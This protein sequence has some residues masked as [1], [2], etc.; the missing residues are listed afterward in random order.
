M[1]YATK[2][3]IKGQIVIPGPLRKKHH[4]EPGTTVEV[5]E[6][7]NVICIAPRAAEPIDAA[8]GMLPASPSLAEDL[9]RDRDED[10]QR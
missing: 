8:F 5:F 6:Y 7:G 3:S 9:L 10:R 2:V 1:P 4:L